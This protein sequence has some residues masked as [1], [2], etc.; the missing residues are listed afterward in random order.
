MVKIRLRRTGKKKQP[1]YRLVVTDSRSPRDGR[2]IEIIGHYLPIRQPKVLN[3]KADRAR[4]WLSVGARPS[5]TVEHLLKQV[6][7]LDNDGRITAPSEDES[8]YGF[9]QPAAS[10]AAPA[11]NGGPAVAAVATPDTAPATDEPDGT[12]EHEGTHPEESPDTSEEDA[13]EED[14]TEEG[15]DTDEGE[16]LGDG[17]DEKTP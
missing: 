13:T 10:Y 15:A 7:I 12:D 9:V 1:C 2:F 8:E 6:N 11:S 14:A 16:P 4:Y 3:V 5:E 17:D